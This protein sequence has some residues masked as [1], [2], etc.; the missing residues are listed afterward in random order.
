MQLLCWWLS[1]ARLSLVLIKAG[2]DQ[3]A[4]EVGTCVE[5]EVRVGVGFHVAHLARRFQVRKLLCS[6]TFEH[7]CVLSSHM[8]THRVYRVP[9]CTYVATKI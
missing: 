2:T 9:Q 1:A 3:G 4:L 8:C 6:A 5:V 7:Y